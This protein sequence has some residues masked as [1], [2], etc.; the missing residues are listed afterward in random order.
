MNLTNMIDSSEV[1]DRTKDFY[2]YLESNK[3]LINEIFQVIYEDLKSQFINVTNED[4]T[5]CIKTKNSK[6]ANKIFPMV[7]DCIK[8]HTNDYMKNDTKFPI[9]IATVT[10]TDESIL[11][12]KKI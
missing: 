2:K 9:S 8:K 6:S 4:N 1:I 3:E 5:I 11:V 10:T 7:W 12:S